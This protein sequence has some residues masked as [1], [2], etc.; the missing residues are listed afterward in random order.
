MIGLCQKGKKYWS[1]TE[2]VLEI[3]RITNHDSIF[4]ALV[5]LIVRFWIHY[6]K[7]KSR[8]ENY[9]SKLCVYFSVNR[10]I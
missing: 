5:I 9:I 1:V 7:Q 8:M 10:P 4:G 6:Y 2:F 3:K